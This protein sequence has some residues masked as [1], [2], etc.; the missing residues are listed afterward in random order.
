MHATAVDPSGN[1]EHDG[2]GVGSDAAV[3]DVVQLDSR[4]VESTV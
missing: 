2:I 1:A 4:T 3:D